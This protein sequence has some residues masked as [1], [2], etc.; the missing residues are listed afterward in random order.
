M[1]RRSASPQVWAAIDARL[2]GLGL[3]LHPDKTRI[4]YCKDERRRGEYEH[5]SF[6]FLGYTFRPRKAKGRDGGLYLGFLPAVSA[7]ALTRMG[8]TLRRWRLHLPITRSLDE[9]A[10]EINPV[11]RGWTIAAGSTGRRCCPSSGAST[12]T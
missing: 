1:D 7:A 12:P 4:V 8:R 11:V 3:Q 10:D 9:L 6:T 5:T 2:T